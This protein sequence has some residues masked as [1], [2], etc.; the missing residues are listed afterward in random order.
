MPIQR[1]DSTASKFRNIEVVTE[2]VKIA[3]PKTA[4]ANAE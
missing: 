2:N 4:K 3:G 1:Y